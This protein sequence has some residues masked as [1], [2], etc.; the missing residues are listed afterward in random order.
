MVSSRVAAEPEPEPAPGMALGVPTPRSIARS[1]LRAGQDVHTVPQKQ[2][3]AARLVLRKLCGMGG[4]DRRD[5]TAPGGQAALALASECAP[6]AL[7]FSGR[8]SENSFN[9]RNQGGRSQMSIST[10]AHTHASTSSR[11]RNGSTVPPER[12]PLWMLHVWEELD[13][14]FRLPHSNRA[15]SD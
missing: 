8:A 11:P 14:I 1:P 5:L 15:N 2:T 12:R 3:S 4:W 10:G 9:Q 7:G 13:E 6:T